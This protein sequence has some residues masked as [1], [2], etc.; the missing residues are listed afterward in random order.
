[1]V[2][3]HLEEGSLEDARERAAFASAVTS[4]GLF[5]YWRWSATRD[6]RTPIG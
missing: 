3:I 4:N 2:R 5:G 1:M 6:S